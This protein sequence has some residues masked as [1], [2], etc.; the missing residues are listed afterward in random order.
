MKA[1]K[2]E[3]NKLVVEIKEAN[4]KIASLNAKFAAETE[5]QEKVNAEQKVKIEALEK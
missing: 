4:E 3:K 1:E 5:A 2:E